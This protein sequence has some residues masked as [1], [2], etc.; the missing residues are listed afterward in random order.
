MQYRVLAGR[1]VV[2]EDDLASEEAAHD[3]CEVLSI[4]AVVIRGMP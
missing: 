1:A 3:L 4:C 2:V